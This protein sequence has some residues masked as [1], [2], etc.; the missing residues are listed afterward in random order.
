VVN[1]SLIFSKE[2]SRH[3]HGAKQGKAGQS[4]A[5]QG[6][7]RQAGQSRAKQVVLPDIR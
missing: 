1:F 3:V 7:V 6:K 5:K 4:R 2:L